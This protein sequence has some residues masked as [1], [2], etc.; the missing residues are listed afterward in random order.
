MKQIFTSLLFLLMLAATPLQAQMLPQKANPNNPQMIDR[1]VAV[2]N[3]GVILQSDLDQAMQTVMQQYAGHESELPP[4]NVLER[5]VL[6]RLI[7]M[8]LQVQKAA[9]QGVR[10]SN[11]E[12]NQ[13]T[14]NV[15]KQNH[16]SV[17]QLRAAIQQQGGSFSDFQQ[18]LAQQVMVQRL[19]DSVIKKDVTITDAEVD[20]LLKNPA[21]SG[22][23][24]HLA[25]IRI[26]TPSGASASDIQSA[27]DKAEA[28]IK[29]IRGGTSFSSAAIQYS[30]ADDALKGG[31]LGWRSLD[32]VPPAFV[33][34]IGKMQPGQI[35]PPLRGP[36]GFQILKLI[37]RRAPQAKMVTEYHARQILIRP[38]QL[39]SPKQAEKKINDIY[40]RIVDKHEDFAKLAKKYS[41]DDTT[42]NNGGDMD[43]FPADAWG[44]A[45][46]QQLESLKDGQVSKPFQVQGAWDIVKRVGV[47]HKDRTDQMR[48]KQARQAIG[49][50]KAREAYEN[51]LRQ[52]RA[53]AYVS[54]RV[55][56]LRKPDNSG[57]S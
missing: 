54:I 20:N 29:A 17:D 9:E 35:S 50:R 47:R 15:A 3:D 43:W 39:V 30:D 27:H 25:H 32:E 1:I 4:R 28:A 19:R 12:V 40:H 45:I 2:V 41:D 49:T 18:K 31:D 33:D 8:K 56:S 6:Q 16:M 48:R 7:L 10:V 37:G 36:N 55:P 14:A 57:K 51:F 22:A 5:Q 26:T 21:Y 38:T 44:S 23:Q 11:D 13:A 42:A 34:I 46:Q 53:Q 24:V 52:L